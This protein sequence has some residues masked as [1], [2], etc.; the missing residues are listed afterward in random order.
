MTAGGE[1][2]APLAREAA[3]IVPKIFIN[4]F[5]ILLNGIIQVSF[6]NT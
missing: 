5:N 2:S 1:R 3:K 6:L 4:Y